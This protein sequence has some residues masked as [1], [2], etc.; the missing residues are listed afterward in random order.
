MRGDG[1]GFLAASLAVFIAIGPVVVGQSV[2]RQGGEF[3]V[4]SYTP[5][6][7]Y[8]PA[9]ASDGDGD[10]VV[11]WTSYGQDG[12]TRGIF[13]RR[14]DP[15]GVAQGAEFQVNSVTSSHQSFPAVAAEANGDFVVAWQGI[16]N[17]SGGYGI[18]AQRFDSSAAPVGSEFRVNSYTAYNQFFPAV[19]SD[20]DGDF[21]VVW[22]SL[23]QDGF[24]GGIFA[25]RFD[26]SGARQ[27]GEFQANS[28]TA[29]YQSLGKVAVDSDG[30]FV[31]AWTSYNQDGVLNYGAF[32]QRFDSAGLPRGAEFQVN[33]YTT[34]GQRSVAIGSAGDGDF[35]IA[36]MSAQ[37]G[38]NYGIFARRFDS[39]GVP[40]GVEFQV[41][42]YTTGFQR[43]PAI[44][45]DTDGDFVVVWM[46]A[47]Q[48][49]SDYGVFARRFSSAGG[50]SSA[51][52][53]VNTRTANRQYTPA[54]S[55]ENDGDFVVAWTSSGGQDGDLHGA[56]G[57]R[58][59]RVDLA[60]LDIDGNGT[61][62]ALGDGLLVLRSQFGFTGA[63]LTTGVVGAG[64]I[65]C[66]AAA[67]QAYI[68]GLGMTL[69]IDGNKTVDPLTDGLLVL[70][71]L[72]GF[73]GTP[74]TT[75]VVG[76]GCSRCDAAMIEPYL[77]TLD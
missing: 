4:N 74:L 7:Q 5:S 18:F 43:T 39:T 70:R 62:D 29:S 27:G 47:G 54:V 12:S 69:D 63:A 64:C 2:V 71:F 48:D 13:A 30:D 40:R 72:F 14:F 36:W 50:P 57:Q 11:A 77:Q 17:Y 37:D 65:R 61:L 66:D 46:S 51:E 33:S 9:L 42:T 67:I 73:T 23:A 41:N 38:S 25:Q 55:S 56:F 44:A 15:A 10:F 19:A 22:H 35:V 28:F 20:S 75:G 59:S 8:L 16:G 58:F 52:F 45:T 76:S 49:R 60:T 24:A 6:V 1:A 68:S 3:Q 21:I 53:I 26:S 34:G 31:V 32:A